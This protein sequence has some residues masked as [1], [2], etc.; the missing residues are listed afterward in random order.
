MNTGIRAVQGRELLAFFNGDR[1]R[2]GAEMA[3]AAAGQVCD[4]EASLRPRERKPLS[5]QVDLAP[6]LDGGPGELEW[7]IET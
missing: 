6:S 5:V 7:T 4:F 1:A 2:V 3:L